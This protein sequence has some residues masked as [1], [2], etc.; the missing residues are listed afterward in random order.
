MI[1]TSDGQNSL[2][3]FWDAL[4]GEGL[5]ASARTR[6]ERVCEETGAG[7]PVVMALSE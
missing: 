4:L 3:K 1:S 6:V 2:D 5:E 7:L